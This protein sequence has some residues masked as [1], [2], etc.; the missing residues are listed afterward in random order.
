M[1]FGELQAVARKYE[2]VSRDRSTYTAPL[3]PLPIPVM[4]ARFMLF[5]FVRYC[6][7]HGLAMNDIAVELERGMQ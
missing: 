3:H 2:W 6:E 7:Y 1:T 4:T 5:D